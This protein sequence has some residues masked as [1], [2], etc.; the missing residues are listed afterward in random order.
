MI[1][2]LLEL[3]TGFLIAISMLLTFF[4]YKTA[5]AFYV[6]KKL[7]CGPSVNCSLQSPADKSWGLFA[8]PSDLWCT[9][10]CWSMPSDQK[11]GWW[12]VWIFQGMF[13]HGKVGR[14]KPFIPE[15]RVRLV[16]NFCFSSLWLLLYVFSV[17][18]D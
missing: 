12:F 5:V 15:D 13:K 11:D 18:H 3:R 2:A 7:S 16:Q 17:E 1:Q 6:S 8:R 4:S 10:F 9:K 14:A